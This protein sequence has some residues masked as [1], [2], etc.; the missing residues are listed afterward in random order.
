MRL[1]LLPTLFIPT[2]LNNYNILCFDP[3][4]C[5]SVHDQGQVCYYDAVKDEFANGVNSRRGHTT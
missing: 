5:L 1:R 2:K 4:K 3:S